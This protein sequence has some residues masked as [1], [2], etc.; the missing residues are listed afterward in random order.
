MSAS[1]PPS[2]ASLNAISVNSWDQNASFWDDYM[3]SDGNDFFS[4]LELPGVERLAAIREGDRV[5][6]LAT[7]NGLLARRLAE[8]GAIVT[9]T[10]ASRGMLTCAERRMEDHESLQEKI[11]YQLLDVT[12]EQDLQSMVSQ[13]DKVSFVHRCSNKRSELMMYVSSMMVLIQLP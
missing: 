4:V 8:L 10:D 11:T 13:A 3:G 2:I 7:G 5:L 9:A 12:S 6:D 1:S